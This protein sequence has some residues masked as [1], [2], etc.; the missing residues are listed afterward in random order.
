LDGHAIFSAFLF[1]FS[2]LL[3]H[4]TSAL[5]LFSQMAASVRYLRNSV[6]EE[7]KEIIELAHKY[8]AASPE[9][10]NTW[11]QQ[12]RDMF[13]SEEVAHQYFSN[14]HALEKIEETLQRMKGWIQ[15]SQ[16]VSCCHPLTASC[17]HVRLDLISD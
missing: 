2:S 1:A 3:T 13:L 7:L 9:L 14:K 5:L 6:N 15:T 11:N 8:G 12:W 4:F 17:A 16:K 10:M